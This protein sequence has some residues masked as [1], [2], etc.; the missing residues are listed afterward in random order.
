MDPLNVLAKFEMSSLSRS[1]DNR[2][3]QKIYRYSSCCSS[4]SSCWDDLFK[5]AK[6]SQNFTS[7]RDETRPECSSGKYASIDGVYIF[8]TLRHTFEM[9][10]M[11]SFHAKKCC[12]LVIV[13]VQRTYTAAS[14]SSW[15]IAHSYVLTLWIFPT[16]GYKIYSEHDNAAAAAANDDDDD[17]D[18]DDDND[19]KK[20]ELS[21]RWQRDA[22]YMGVLKFFETPWVRPRLLFPKFLMSFC[23]D[24]SY[25][26]A[27]KIWSWRLYP[28][29]K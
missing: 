13:F 14:V 5:K 28:F 10:A 19:N 15:S 24:R 3:T 12:H 2:G 20:A 9:A 8:L 18:D 11:T 21:Q 6:S 26:C 29:L 17:D 27:Y 23:S 22:R 4:C 1:W 7:D 16:T 25:E